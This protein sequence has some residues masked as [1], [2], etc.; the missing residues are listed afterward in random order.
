MRRPGNE[1]TLSPGRLLLWIAWSLYFDITVSL[2]LGRVPVEKLQEAHTDHKSAGF[3]VPTDHEF[4]KGWS[5]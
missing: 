5:L 2:Q 1:A 4:P 3:P